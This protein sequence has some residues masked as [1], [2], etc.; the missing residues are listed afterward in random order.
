MTI[1]KQ[2]TLEKINLCFSEIEKCRQLLGNNRADDFCGRLLSIYIMIRIDDISKMWSHSITKG[3]I[4]RLLSDEAKAVYNKDFRNVRDKLG[5]HYQTPSDNKDI[6]IVESSILF[7]S[8]NFESVSLLIDEFIAAEQLINSNRN[9]FTG[10]DN[11]DD[12]MLAIEAID[13]L[14]ADDKSHITNSALDLFGINKVGVISCTNGQ[15]KAQYLKG[16]EL[17]VDYA[18]YLANKPYH[19]IDVQRLF[20]R[21]LVCFI[22]NYHDNLF[23]R[24]ELNLSANQY[25]EGFDAMYKTLY[26][27]CDNKTILDTAF[28]EFEIIYHTDE[29]FKRNRKVRDHSCAHFDEESNVDEINKILDS[30]N[31][32]EL[33]TH[34]CNMLNL[35]NYICNNMLALSFLQIPPRSVLYNVQIEN[36]DGIT[37]FFGEKPNDNLSFKMMSPKDIIKSIRKKDIHYGEALEQMKERLFSQNLNHYHQMIAAIGQRLHELNDFTPDLFDIIDGLYNA[38]RGYPDRLQRSIADLIND[39]QINSTVKVHLIWVLSSICIK[40]ECFDILDILQDLIKCDYYPIQCL[41]FIG[42]LHY[43]MSDRIPF[44]DSRSKPREVDIDFQRFLQTKNNPTLKLGIWLALNQHWMYDSDYM[45]DRK[46]EP[47][48][49]SFL[50]NG[51]HESLQNYYNYAKI[52]ENDKDIL[53]KFEKTCHYLLLLQMLTQYEILRNQKPNAFLE[54]WNSHCFI[55]CR[56]DLYESLGVGLMTELNG[57][58][59]TARSI[60]KT[61]V[62][63]NPINRDA[64]NTLAEFEKRNK[65]E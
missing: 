11:V 44:V 4:E 62:K 56:T 34:Y 38:K 42:Y 39:D 23:T 54:L 12:L 28:G 32:N 17:M 49:D 64:I 26:S 5:A 48:Y 53:N 13:N 46:Q 61:I 31:Y 3:E 52:N 50:K 65:K 35:F 6:D 43:L 14:Y 47:I 40:D 55:K 1:I 8:F 22:Y 15:R 24:K 36:M 25:E 10:F 57:E 29:F 33:Y 37:N 18:Y 7:R 45:L 21:M 60:F 41:A 51:L 16:V 27:P 63:D 59:E 30:L 9:Q 20:K 58:I 2:E 19:S